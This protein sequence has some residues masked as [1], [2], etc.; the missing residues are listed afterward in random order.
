MPEGLQAALSVQEFND[1]VAYLES[2][3]TDPR[4][5]LSPPASPPKDWTELCPG[6]GLLGWHQDANKS[7][8]TSGVSSGWTRPEA[9]LE[10]TSGGLLWCDRVFADFVL[11]FEWRWVDAPQFKEQPLLDAQGHPERG[12][13]GAVLVERV[14]EAG[15]ARVFLLGPLGPQITLSCG[16]GGSGGVAQRQSDGRD[17]SM[18][19]PHARGDRPVGQWNQMEVGVRGARLNIRLNGTE[20]LPSFRWSGSKP[21]GPIGLQSRAGRIQF[22]ALA[23]QTLTSE[24]K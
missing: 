2:L 14:L 12:E 18:A 24:E 23:L 1:L 21:T 15:E 5:A 17:I 6:P 11:R 4:R 13:A 16:P 3:K 19:S 9:V 7:P 22:R 20:V 8:S 10:G